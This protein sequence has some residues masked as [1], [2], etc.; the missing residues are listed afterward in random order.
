VLG[1]HSGSCCLNVNE[2]AGIAAAVKEADA[3]ADLVVVSFHGGAEGAEHRH[4][5]GQVEVAWGEPRGDVKAFARAAVDA[6][7]DLVLGH[8]P[9]VVRAMEVYRE[10]LIAYSLGNL[11]GFRQFGTQGGWGG[12]SVVL[13]AALAKDGRIASARLHPI[14]LDGDSRP[15]PDPSGKGLDAVRE[16]SAADFPDTGVRVGKDGALDWAR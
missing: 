10:R 12:A 5:L 16:L 9:H 14:A 15:H 7:A 4:V 13:D 8:G 1:A 2:P 6:G 3:W 11:C